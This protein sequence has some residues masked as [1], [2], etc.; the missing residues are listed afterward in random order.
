[1][2]YQNT[3]VSTYSS[4]VPSNDL[5]RG[6]NSNSIYKRRSLVLR[7]FLNY[8]QNFESGA[9]QMCYGSNLRYHKTDKSTTKS[10]VSLGE[11]RTFVGS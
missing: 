9:L 3:L 8:L 2:K 10:T 6:E 7:L 11:V 1:M 4:G 5:E